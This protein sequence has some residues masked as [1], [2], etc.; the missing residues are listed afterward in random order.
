MKKFSYNLNAVHGAVIFECDTEA[1]NGQVH[2]T[3][4]PGLVVGTSEWAWVTEDNA[5]RI[6]AALSFFSETSTKEIQRLATEAC[7]NK[8]TVVKG[9][10]Q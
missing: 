10:T 8:P 6:C 4:T 1:S 2:D 7:K 9:G 5:R 3:S